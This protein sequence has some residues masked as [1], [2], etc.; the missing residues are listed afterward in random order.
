MIPENNTVLGKQCPTEVKIGKRLHPVVSRRRTNIKVQLHMSQ[1]RKTNHSSIHRHVTLSSCK[2][3]L[4]CERIDPSGNRWTLF[5]SSLRMMLWN[6]RSMIHTAS[7]CSHLMM[8]KVVVV[9]V[10]FAV[11]S[12]YVLVAI[13]DR[14]KLTRKNELKNRLDQ[15]V[16][17]DFSVVIGCYRL[18]PGCKT[19]L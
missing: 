6:H 18:F 12:H 3:V 1:A 2:L 8:M 9:V 17:C 4:D 19:I 14:Q 5:F 10:G 11:L 13:V 16:R 15:S 7:F